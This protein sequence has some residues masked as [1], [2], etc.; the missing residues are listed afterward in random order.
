ME[1]TNPN[2]T[3]FSLFENLDD[4]LNMLREVWKSSGSLYDV[5]RREAVPG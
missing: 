1:R 3:F 4:V 5:V 2:P